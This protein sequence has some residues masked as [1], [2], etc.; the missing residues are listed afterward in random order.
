MSLLGADMDAGFKWK[1]TIDPV[2]QR[3]LE[4]E[5]DVINGESVVTTIT[6]IAGDTAFFSSPTSG[7]NKTIPVDRDVIFNSQ[8]WYPNLY[9][10]FIKKGTSEKKYKVYDPVKGEITEKGYARKSEETIV[11]SDSTFQTLV[12]EE[13]DFSTGD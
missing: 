11:L 8:T 10:D 12:I 7:V 1:F 9:N 3:A 6:R 13:T 4:I 2:T 5:M